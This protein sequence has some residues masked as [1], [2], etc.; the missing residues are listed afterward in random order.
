MKI[1]KI[2][3][4][5]ALLLLMFMFSGCGTTY[6]VD[7]S[8]FGGFTLTS[9]G[10]EISLSD[11]EFDELTSEEQQ[12]GLLT[13]MPSTSIEAWTDPENVP[14][15]EEKGWV[16]TVYVKAVDTGITLNSLQI[17]TYPPDHPDSPVIITL[18]Q[19][20]I[21]VIFGNNYIP[22]GGEIS[23]EESQSLR[24]IKKA[25]GDE[26]NVYLIKKYTFYGT[27]DKGL[28]VKASTTV[29]LLK[30]ESAGGDK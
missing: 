1:F 11:N 4:F 18:P 12:G 15:D 16:Y 27:T 17:E 2:F 8:E 3:V 20:F 23:A 26:E 24:Y 25:K 28:N 6:T 7:E 13:A 10:T 22:E 19:N 14:Y 5:L 29:Y 9:P 21:K 30:N